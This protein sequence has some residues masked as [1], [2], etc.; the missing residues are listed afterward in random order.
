MKKN[1]KQLLL[2]L[3]TCSLAVVGMS[4]IASLPKTAVASAE[5]N[6]SLKFIDTTLIET[7]FGVWGDRVTPTFVTENAISGNAV[8][9]DATATG[10]FAALEVFSGKTVTAGET[11]HIRFKVKGDGTSFHLYQNQEKWEL[12]DDWINTTFEWVEYSYDY[13][14]A[15]TT[16]QYGLFM[17]QIASMPSASGCFYIDDMSV[18]KTK[19][20]ASGSAVG[21]LP[22]L[23]DEHVWKIDGQEITADTV[24]NYTE[25]KTA[26]VGM[27][28][29]KYSLKFVDTTLIETGFGVW[30][31]ATPSFVQENAI[32]GSA[33]KVEATATGGF[34]ALEVFPNKTVTAGETY[35]IRFKVKGD[36]TQFHL[37]QNQASWELIDDWINTTSEWVEYSYDYTVAN[38]TEQYGLFMCQIMSIPSTSGCFYIEDLSVEKTK[39]LTEG[40]A[41]G[42]LPALAEMQYWAVDGQ[43]ITADALWDWTE[44]KTATVME[45]Q[46]ITFAYPDMIEDMPTED[47][48]GAVYNTTATVTETDAYAGKALH[49]TVGTENEELPSS[50]WICLAAE[51][52]PAGEYVVNF[53]MKNSKYVNLMYQIGSNDYSLTTSLQANVGDKAE[54]TD[55]TYGITLTEEA[56]RLYLLIQAHA[57][58]GDVYVDEITFTLKESNSKVVMDGEKIGVLPAIPEKMGYIGVWTIDGETVTA[59]T[60]WAGDSKTAKIDYTPI[61]YTVTFKN[62]D[63]V[64]GTQT[65]TVEDTEITVPEVPAKEY[66]TGAWESY[67]LGGGDKTVNAVYTAIEYTVTFMNG[68]EVV[69]NQTY[70]V[71]NTEITEPEVPVKEYYTGVWENYELTNGDKTVNAVYTAIKYTVTFMNS[72]EVLGTQTYTVEDTEITEPEVPAREHYVGAWESYELNGG[73]KT[74]NAVYT[75][76]EYTVTFMADGVEVDKVNYTVEDTAI[77]EPTVPAKEGYGGKWEAYAL[78]GGDITVNAVYVAGVYTVTFKVDGVTVAVEEYT[79]EDTEITMPEVPAKEHYTG[80]WESYELNGGDKTVNAVYTALEYTVT[81]KNGDEVVDTQTYTVEDMDITVPEVP[82]KDGYIGEWESYELGGGDKTVNAVYTEIPV[83]DDSS[84]EEN[85]SSEKD[86]ASNAVNSSDGNSVVASGCFGSVSGAT[87]GI[88]MLGV[89]V[90]ALLKKKED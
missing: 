60:V 67:E 37:F 31:E 81:F 61:E 59:D 4:A 50:P 3:A 90:A 46:T 20:V 58:K 16:N 7:G 26:V 25:D 82:E 9:V 12:I 71:E 1:V 23:D 38:T 41:I 44:S 83:V 85:S 72:E 53:K 22:A 69:G 18:E 78:V 86:S 56:S 47:Y 13:T 29:T 68:E 43:K 63:D 40:S 74:I 88:V 17:C 48:F 10:G 64:V 28:A 32:S 45:L 76:I 51:A 66:Y 84:S 49:F 19:T 52:V 75:A 33:V 27:A 62:G 42:E 80:V 77:V 11:Y 39:K 65:Y 30:G 87:I 6:Y 24:W 34:A 73:N 79:I 35:H 89:A 14:V 54:W 5:E 2:S 70:T 8:K 57:G 21:E 36:G 15:N 55:Y